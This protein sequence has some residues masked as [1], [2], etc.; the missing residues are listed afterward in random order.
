MK[1]PP[2]IESPARRLMLSGLAVLPLLH[3]RAIRA[4]GPSLV[5]RPDGG[6]RLLP[7]SPVFA[8]GAVAEPG[9]AMVHALLSRWLPLEQG[10]EL[11][12]R[13]LRSIDRP[14]QALCGMQLRLPRQLSIEEF[15]AF[16]APYVARLERWGVVR[17]RVNPVSRTNVSP[18][19]AAP[20]EA[21]LHA[22]TYTI[23]Y[24][25]IARTFTMSGMTERGPGGSIVAQGD[26]SPEGMRSKLAYVLGAVSDRLAELGFGWRDA[27]HVD[28]YSGVEV[29]GALGALAARA[30]GALP[31]GVRWYYGRPPVTGLEIELE[32]RAVLREEV[33]EA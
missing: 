21:S 32:A 11:V 7:G 1:P 12:E 9:F 13:H 18:A 14:M 20:G 8:G 6:F 15:T 16:N 4:Q 28:L 26:A 30:S 19:E 22:F 25:G 27:T 3:A 31:R 23:P 2:T 10:Y 29:P 33:V 17:D 24:A 5:S